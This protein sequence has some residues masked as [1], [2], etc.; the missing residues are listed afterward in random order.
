M[1]TAEHTIEASATLKTAKLGSAMKS[2]TWPCRKPGSRKSRSM[3]VADRA[4]EQPAEG[5]RPGQAAEPARRAHDDDD[6][7]DRDRRE[8]DR[9]AR[10]DAERGARSCAGT[11]NR[12]Q[13]PR[14]STGG[15]ALE[16]AH[17][18]VLRDLVEEHHGRR[19]GERDADE[20]AVAGRRGAGG[21]GRRGTGV[22][23]VG[24]GVAHERREY[25][26]GGPRPRIAGALSAPAGRRPPRSAPLLELLAATQSVARGNA[27]SRSLPIGVAAAL[28]D[29]VR[30]VVE[31]GQRPLVL[32]QAA[33][34]RCSPGDISCSRSN[35]LVPASAWS[36]PAPSPE[37]RSRSAMPSSASLICSCTRAIST[38]SS[39]RTA[40]SSAL[41]HGDSSSRTAS[42]RRAALAGAAFAGAALAGT[43]FAAFTGTA[44]AAF[45]GAAFAGAAFAGAAFAGAALAAF[46]GAAFAVFAVF[47]GAALVPLA[48]A[49]FAAFAGA[50]F[51]AL[52]GAAFAG[53]A[54]AA[55]AGAA[56]AAF[57]GAALVPLAG[58]A[59]AALAGAAFAGPALAGAALAGADFA[60]FAGAGLVTLAGA[61][62]AAFAGAA[63]AAQPSCRSSLRRLGGGRLRGSASRGRRRLLRGRSHRRLLVRAPPAPAARVVRQGPRGDESSLRVTRG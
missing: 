28:A 54:L 47:A 55:F 32:Q 4:P 29:P 11:S 24:Y 60:A 2:T 53:A 27:C 3:Q 51:A 44:L 33:R 21:D 41:V 39:V 38:P 12:T 34:G 26:A 49:A 43:A 1:R 30:A 22:V 61:V 23:I 59:F 50:A 16:V 20:V 42:R 14:T 13:V 15:V 25:V 56:L 7:G 58:E 8:Q 48:G 40:A 19:H 63:F 9:D 62:F 5:D 18:E 31:P 57:A 46:A 36:S 6:D 45:A 37:S 10:A 35:V 52:A 17:G